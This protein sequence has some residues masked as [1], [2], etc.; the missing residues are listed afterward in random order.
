MEEA[1]IFHRKRSAAF[2]TTAAAACAAVLSCGHAPRGREG[3]ADGRVARFRAAIAALPACPADLRSDTSS[4][5]EALARRWLPNDCLSVHGRLVAAPTFDDTP[6]EG[7]G[8]C[9]AGWVLWSDSSPPPLTRPEH[10]SADRHGI[11]L[12]RPRVPADLG[13]AAPNDSRLPDAIHD[14]E[15]PDADTL[16][17]GGKPVEVAVVG[18]V[19]L[20]R[21]HDGHVSFDPEAY[22]GVVATP[23]DLA[24]WP[25][26]V[27]Y[28]C[29]LAR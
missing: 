29:R 1:V 19:V 8:R 13:C 28:V 7:C 27:Q 14:G 17:S 9:D 26:R 3:Q 22:V 11:P 18:S 21:A 4:V 24:V 20:D 2:V 15:P 10:L 25:L 23:Q 5:E 6:M 12:I 16:V